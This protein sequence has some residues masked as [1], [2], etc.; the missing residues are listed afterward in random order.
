MM[1]EVTR[2]DAVEMKRMCSV[3]SILHTVGLI[4][5]GYYS[6]TSPLQVVYGIDLVIAN[7]SELAMT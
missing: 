5:M 6:I 7:A 1:A 3:V 4:I 2:S